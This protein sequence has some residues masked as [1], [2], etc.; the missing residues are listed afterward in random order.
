MFQAEM[1]AVK[2]HNSTS[3]LTLDCIRYL[4]SSENLVYYDNSVDTAS[5]LWKTST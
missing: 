2:S 5:E 1:P 4:F 3:L